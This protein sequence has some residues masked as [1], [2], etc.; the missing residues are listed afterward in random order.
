[1]Q[2]E[3]EPGDQAS[4]SRHMESVLLQSNRCS[5]TFRE[6]TWLDMKLIFRLLFRLLF[7]AAILPFVLPTSSYASDLKG[8]ASSSGFQRFMLGAFE[9][10]A[11]S[12]GAIG[13]SLA[14]LVQPAHREM[15]VDA[16]R[17]SGTEGQ[18]TSV[19][20]FLIKTP[21]RLVLVDAGD[22][23]G[24]RPGLGHLMASLH[25][26]GYQPEQVDTILITHMH[27]DHIGGVSRNGM[28]LFPN[29]TLFIERREAEFWLDDARNAAPEPLPTF[30]RVARAAVQPY[31]DIGRLHL[32]DAIDSEVVPGVRIH[33]AA[34]HTPG[35][36]AF[37]VESQGRHLLLW[38]DLVHM[39]QI[40]FERP[41]VGLTFDVDQESA[42]EQR[43]KVFE[44]AARG[45]WLIGAAHI[46]FPGLGRIKQTA[47][48]SFQWI[49]EPTMR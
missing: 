38:G 11:L 14:D 33:S 23:P 9:I 34:G 41:D 16:L 3:W 30:A 36:T 31:R 13:L 7:A 29:A 35:H 32:F 12:D 48:G 10:T 46:S 25:A 28:A 44:E 1:M 47:P 20:A 45:H 49:A 22:P 8:A 42:A 19:N 2:G 17:K 43:R 4:R 5:S 27:R 6:I 21:D 40:Q 18:A 37:L 15:T 24:L 26:A 39:P